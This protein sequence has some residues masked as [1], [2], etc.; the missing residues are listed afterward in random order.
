MFLELDRDRHEGSERRPKDFLA[1]SVF[2]V[3]LIL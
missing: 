3:S 2:D 1:A